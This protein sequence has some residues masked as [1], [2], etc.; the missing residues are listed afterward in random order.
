MTVEEN[1]KQ[2]GG[3]PNLLTNDKSE[4]IEAVNKRIDDITLSI[5]HAIQKA[6][7]SRIT[8]EKT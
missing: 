3:V 4:F 7:T 5:S 2:K 1:C 6:A 8:I